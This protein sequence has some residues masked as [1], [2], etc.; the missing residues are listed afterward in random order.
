MANIQQGINQMLGMGAA[1]AGL[2]GITAERRDLKKLKKMDK[3][4]SA[5]VKNI[6]D[7]EMP[8]AMGKFADDLPSEDKKVLNR[9]NEAALKKNVEFNER[10]GELSSYQES[11]A[12]SM[13][14]RNPT[15]EN[16]ERMKAYKAEADKRKE[17][18][19]RDVGRLE[20]SRRRKDARNA[21][22][23]AQRAAIKAQ[24]VTIGGDQVSLEELPKDLQNAI[25]NINKKGGNK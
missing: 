22:R 17:I 25:I 4:A 9:K 12:R 5:E 7:K 13:F 20:E 6:V 8:E 10:L 21:A 11:T 16:Y 2:S 24:K 14:E 3:I 18:I 19:E 15:S 1:L 23:Q